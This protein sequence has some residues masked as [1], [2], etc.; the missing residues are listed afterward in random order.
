MMGEQRHIVVHQRVED[1]CELT[2]GILPFIHTQQRKD[3]LDQLQKAAACGDWNEM[4]WYLWDGYAE[5]MGLV[6]KP[7]G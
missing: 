3:L 7:K 6:E 4:T 2:H 5:K 1:I